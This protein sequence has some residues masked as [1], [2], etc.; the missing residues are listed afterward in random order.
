[1]RRLRNDSIKK[2]E[3]SLSYNSKET[4]IRKIYDF[5]LNSRFG[6]SSR[7]GA[8]YKY[9]LADQINNLVIQLAIFLILLLLREQ[10]FFFSNTNRPANRQQYVESIT[11]LREIY[12]NLKF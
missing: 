1:M 12:Q 5:A 10:N 4:K 7:G 2:S 8:D 11:K 9:Q 3:S 6:L